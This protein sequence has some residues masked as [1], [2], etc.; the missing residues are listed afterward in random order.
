MTPMFWWDREGRTQILL[1]M[2]PDH[3][4]DVVAGIL[5]TTKQA[6]YVK[7]HRL[8]IASNHWEQ[9][10]RKKTNVDVDYFR[11]EISDAMAY[12]LGYIWADGNVRRVRGCKVVGGLRFNCHKRDEDILVKILEAVK[13]IGELKFQP[14]FI[15]KK[16][17]KDGNKVSA[18]IYNQVFVEPL[19]TRFGIIPAKSYYDCPFPDYIP[20]DKWGHFCRGFLDGDGSFH[21]DK[22]MPMDTGYAVSWCGTDLFIEGLRNLLVPLLGVRECEVSE[23]PSQTKIFRS[24]EW[25]SAKDFLTIGEF[26][27]P[28]GTDYLYGNRKRAYFERARELILFGES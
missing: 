9:R 11:R 27:Y 28:D 23:K 7:A 10:A 19:V 2:Y 17:R 1:D 16:G 3:G 15:D 4:P 6:V 14:P 25:G 24:V 22:R 26:L 12:I 13:F 20:E 8:G 21:H 18:E 5:G